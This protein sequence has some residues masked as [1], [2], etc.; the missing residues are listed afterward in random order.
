[1]TIAAGMRG[2]SAIGFSMSNCG[3][4]CTSTASVSLSSMTVYV[5]GGW[6]RGGGGVLGTTGGSG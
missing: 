3:G 1:M 2:F 6:K 5:L 4:T